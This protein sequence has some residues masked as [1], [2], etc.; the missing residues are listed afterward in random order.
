MMTTEPANRINHFVLVA[1]ETLSMRGHASALVKVV[2]GFVTDLAARSKELDQETRITVYV[3]NS[4]SGVR[5][6]IYDMDVLRTPTITGRYHP[7]GMTPLID[8]TCQA[9]DELGETP[10]RHGEHSFVLFALTD[11]QENASRKRPH[12]LAGRIAALPAHWTVAA[13]VPDMMAVAEA[14]RC[15]FPAGN[16]ERWDTTSAHGMTEVGE[17]IRTVSADFMHGRT[18]GV[19]GSRSLFTVNQVTPQAAASALDALVPGSYVLADVPINC[20]IRDFVEQATGVPYA[21]GS[22]YYQLTKVETVQGYKGVAVLSSDGRIYTGQNAR[23]LLG[24]PDYELRVQPA[25]QPGT[26]I[27]VQST[28]VNRKLIG[29]TK[30]LILH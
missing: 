4:S 14:K 5:C 10:E 16:I 15:G 29:G 6:L 22:A 13:F 9:I 24:L 18:Q 26:T 8:A 3:F 28:S 21:K 19:R 17:R 23:Q 30:V 20:E 7:A 12:D 27:F 1:D 25:F 2:D 11:G